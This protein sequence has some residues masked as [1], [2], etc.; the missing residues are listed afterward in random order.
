MILV[1]D[2]YDSFVHNVARYLRELGREVEVRRSDALS[3]DRILERS[4]SHL[5][6]SPGPC[7][8][9]EAGVSVD[10]VRALRGRI[11]VL[12]ICLGH[13]AVARA[14]GAG[15]GPSPQPTH[16]R[17]SPIHHRSTGIL[18]GLPSPFPGGRYHSLTVEPAG[19]PAELEVTAWTGEGEV[20]ALRHVR[21]PVWGVQFHPE[22]V[23]TEGGHRLLANFLA[24]APTGAD[25]RSETQSPPPL[26]P[27]GA[28]GM[29][30]TG[31]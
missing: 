15:I 28:H 6:L 13:Q 9:A 20:M 18:R 23:L 14:Y 12:G 31:P 24:L 29:P 25:A 27:L 3:V 19:L 1:L 11:P 30:T 10:V 26:R 7:T 17:A 21:D 22:S 5:V 4:P 16:G 8:P 2:N